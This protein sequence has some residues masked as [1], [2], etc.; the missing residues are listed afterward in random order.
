MNALAV[1]VWL[2]VAVSSV[3]LLLGGRGRRSSASG[4]AAYLH[5]L[6]EAAF[7]VGGP[8]AV[9]DSALVSLLCDGRLVV[10]GPGIVHARPGV[11]AAD[12]AERAVLQAL[13]RAP[14][15]WL[16]QVRYA[17]MV[18]PAVQETGDAL[19]DRGLI[20]VPGSGRGWRRWGLAQAVVCAVLVPVSLVL[21]FVAWAPERG[22]QVPFVFEVLPALLIGIACGVTGSRRARRRI[23]PAGREALGAMRARYAGDRTPRVQTALFGL[24]GLRDPYLRQQLVPA[25]RGTRLAAAQSGPRRAG[26]SGSSDAAVPFGPLVWCAAADGGGSGSSCAGAGSG[27]GSS[28]SSCSASACST[29][30]GCSSGSGCSGSSGSGCSSSSGSGCSS[31]SSCSSSSGSSCSSSS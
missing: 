20:T 19:A 15:G 4:A 10:G 16:Y 24:R 5:D 30:S 11:R 9:V 28:G 17:A 26:D 12:V 29:G 22:F 27:C 6:S 21:T 25:A 23:T 1:A 8:G 7:L 18:D 14:S 31:A 2:A 13:L 3:L